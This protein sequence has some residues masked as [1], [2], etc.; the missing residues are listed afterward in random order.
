M[1][2]STGITKAN[3]CSEVI[4]ECDGIIK[5]CDESLKE[6]DGLI[7]LYDL[8]LKDCRTVKTGLQV[9]LEE[10]KERENSLL[11]QPLFTGVLGAAVGVIIY[12]L[13]TR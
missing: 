5:K 2:L 1:L 12:G 3:D 11:R 6:R 4:K 10:A 8:A 7:D 9:S 13:V